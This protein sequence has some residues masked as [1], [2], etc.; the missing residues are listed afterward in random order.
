MIF[1]GG[2][3]YFGLFGLHLK[4]DSLLATY[5]ITLVGMPKL[6]P[7]AIILLLSPAN[8]VTVS[9]SNITAANKSFFIFLS[10][11]LLFECKVIFI[12]IAYVKC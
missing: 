2:P 8:D 4:V 6:L 3:K 10:N 9:D 11:H 7:A 12:R 1:V 5:D